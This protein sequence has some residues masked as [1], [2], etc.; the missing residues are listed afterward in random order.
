MNQTDG[1][2]VPVVVGTDLVRHDSCPPGAQPWGTGTKNSPLQYGEVNF[3][4]REQ[5]C[6]SACSPRSSKYLE[7]CLAHGRCSISMSVT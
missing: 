1:L 2:F 7:Q 3:T 5:R 6:L 4:S